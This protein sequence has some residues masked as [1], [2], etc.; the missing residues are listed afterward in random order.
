MKVD[1]MSKLMLGRKRNSGKTKK[2]TKKRSLNLCLI[3]RKVTIIIKNLN[4][5]KNGLNVKL[6]KLFMFKVTKKFCFSFNVPVK[7]RSNQLKKRN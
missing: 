1:R 2:E 5:K 7:N 3:C 4:K 6:V